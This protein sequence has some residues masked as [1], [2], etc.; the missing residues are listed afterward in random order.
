MQLLDHER[1]ETGEL[2]PVLLFLVLEDGADVDDCDVD[3]VEDR[4]VGDGVVV[5]VEDV[6]A[7]CDALDLTTEAD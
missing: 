7:L 4:G 1:G 5:G 3:K 6:D 2:V